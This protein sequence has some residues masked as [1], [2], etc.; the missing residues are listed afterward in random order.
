MHPKQLVQQQ[1]PLQQHTVSHQGPPLEIPHQ[2]HGSSTSQTPQSA[3]VPTHQDKS[4]LGGFGKLWRSGSLRK[5]SPPGGSPPG[6]A[7]R[8]H[9]PPPQVSPQ[10]VQGTMQTSAP[11]G[12]FAQPAYPGVPPMQ[13]NPSG[14]QSGHITQ[15]PS[16]QQQHHPH[17]LPQR[18]PSGIVM[19]GRN[20]SGLGGAVQA[21]PL[22][23]QQGAGS[24]RSSRVSSY[25]GSIAGPGT[26]VQN[27]TT[28]A[29]NS[30]WGKNTSYDGDGWGDGY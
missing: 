26:Q 12:A 28:P 1:Q 15:L 29:N 6:T 4:W 3:T 17:Q 18:Q 9:K 23:S 14:R 11:P 24:G 20:N 5:E 19:H 27:Q 8:L 10:Q 30:G 13:Q 16:Q 21:G 2:G 25:S 7:N 22:Y